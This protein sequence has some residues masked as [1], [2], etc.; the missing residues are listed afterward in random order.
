MSFA[1]THA[2]WLKEHLSSRTGEHKGRLER[3]HGHGEILFLQQVWWPLR[4]H[5]RDLH[6]EFEVMDWRGRPYYADFL[7]ISGQVKLVILIKGYA[8]HVRDLDRRGFCREV[9]RETF[10]Q[11]IGYRIISF[12]YDDV[13]K[14][15]DLCI[16]LLRMM[17]NQFEAADKSTTKSR[18]EEKEVVR[19]AYRSAGIVTPRVVAAHLNVTPKTARLILKRLCQQGMLKPLLA[20]K[21]ERVHKYELARVNLDW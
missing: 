4:G 9:N 10:L 5:L 6:P 11:S 18:L 15:P 17:L 7:W 13:E 1:D 14:R 8:T 12:A 2:Q 20:G 3:G 16:T 21:G 19:L